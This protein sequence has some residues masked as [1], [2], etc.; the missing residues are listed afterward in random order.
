MATRVQKE[1][2]FN[3]ETMKGF[4]TIAEAVKYFS[5]VKQPV[6]QKKIVNLFNEAHELNIG[7]VSLNMA[8]F[9]KDPKQLETFIKRTGKFNSEKSIE[10]VKKSV[11][12]WLGKTPD[13]KYPIGDIRQP[14]SEAKA[15]VVNDTPTE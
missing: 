11:E 12:A 6:R 14:I 9:K 8:V 7:S 13:V 4:A 15:T 1:K 5:Q 3:I 10:R 2:P